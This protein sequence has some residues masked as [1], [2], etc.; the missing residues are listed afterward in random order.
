MSNDQQEQDVV[1]TNELIM[2]R[3]A[4]LEALRAQGLAY[5]AGFQRKDLAATLLDKILDNKVIAS[6]TNSPFCMLTSL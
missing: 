5:P 6:V 1:S 2:Q 4:K 3:R